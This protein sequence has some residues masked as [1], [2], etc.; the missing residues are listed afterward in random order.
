[1]DVA[2]LETILW[3]LILYT[4]RLPIHDEMIKKIKSFSSVEDL[5]RKMF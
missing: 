2:R 4:N 3:A 1:M 5:R